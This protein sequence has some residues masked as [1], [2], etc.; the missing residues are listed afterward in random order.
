MDFEFSDDTLIGLTRAMCNLP[1]END[2]AKRIKIKIGKSAN[3]VDI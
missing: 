1:I 2:K 3:N